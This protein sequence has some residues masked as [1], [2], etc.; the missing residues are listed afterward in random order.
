MG[1]LFPFR[2]TFLPGKGSPIKAARQAAKRHRP[3]LFSRWVPTAG[4]DSF[5]RRRSIL[6][7]L[8]LIPE[9]PRHPLP[10]AQAIRS[11]THL[12]LAPEQVRVIHPARWGPQF[13]AAAPAPIPLGRDQKTFS[14]GPCSFSF[15]EP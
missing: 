6:T 10:W 13:T 7:F 9:P 11:V 12:V 1:S 2:T 3:Q 14:S 15:K 4:R 5:L 8:S